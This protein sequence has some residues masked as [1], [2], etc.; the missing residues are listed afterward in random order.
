MHNGRIVM[1]INIFRKLPD[2][3]G[4]QRLGRLIFRKQVNNSKNVIVN[5]KYEIK[6]L[7]PNLKENV[8][9]EIFINGI[10]EKETSDF[11]VCRIPDEGIFVDIGAN[12]GSITIP[13][14]MN[15]KN[16]KVICIEAS[17]K[18]FNY[19]ETNIKL[20]NLQ[21][22]ILINKAIS[23]K[24]GEEVCF[25][26]PTE[27]F[28]KGHISNDITEQVEKIETIRL[29]T[30]LKDHSISS[31]NF[32]KVDI[33]GYEYF[34]FKGG[35]KLLKSATAPDILFEFEDWAENHII[36]VN[37]GDGQKLLLMYGYKLFKVKKNNKLFPLLFPMIKG[38]SM[39]WA[40][41]K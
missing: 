41:K 9:Y 5:G 27:Q 39:I 15:K 13:V 8:G 38:S 1:L 33:E 24:D 29:D 12:I 26:S 36:G 4:K 6:Y 30:L 21:N 10:Y 40:T 31:V 11:I 28:G 19:L 34:A 7:L 32:I 22:S 14:C 18:V 2:F 16:I 25:Y 35:E 37:P 20:N 3:K 17:R 23:G